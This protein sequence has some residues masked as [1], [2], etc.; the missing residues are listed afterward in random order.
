VLVFLPGWDDISRLYKMLCS[1]N[2]F[3]NPSFVL[4]Q[5]HSGIQKKDQDLVF[6]PLQQGQHKIVL[7]TNI[8][9]KTYIHIKPSLS[10]KYV[11]PTY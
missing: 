10:Y 3:N 2:E 4:I 5:L 1:S 8:A 9:G 6:K 7:A 11:T